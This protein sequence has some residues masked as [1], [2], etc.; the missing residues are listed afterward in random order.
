M[1]QINDDD[2]DG[3]DD[4]DDNGYDG[5]ISGMLDFNLFGIPYVSY[6]YHFANFTSFI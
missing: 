2:N 1:R 4:D 6:A 3:H 5:C